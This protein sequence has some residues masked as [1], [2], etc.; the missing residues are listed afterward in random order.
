MDFL[1]DELDSIRTFE[2]FSQRTS[3]GCESFTLKPYNE[4]SLD[5]DAISRFR[6]GY[7]ALFGSVS[8]KDPLYEDISE[9]RTHAGMEHWLPLF[10]EKMETLVDYVHNFV[11]IFDYQV[12]E[13]AISRSEL[14]RECYDARSD[15]KARG[16]SVSEITYNPLPV[17]NLYLSLEELN[18]S[19][20][21]IR[22]IKFQSFS[23]PKTQLRTIDAGG[24]PGFNFAEARALPNVNIYDALRNHIKGR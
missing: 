11:V 3:G 4:I 2:A 10:H 18:V 1:G 22:K 9:G 8:N 7:R 21:T 24:K 23:A 16:L 6:S 14:I 12:E 13:A 15:M 20:L 5:E 19:F 17:K